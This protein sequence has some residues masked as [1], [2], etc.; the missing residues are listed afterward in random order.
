MLFKQTMNQAVLSKL[1]T[2]AVDLVLLEPSEMMD[3]PLQ[4]VH[5]AAASRR[6]RWT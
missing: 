6:S 2:W 3:T 4:D 5:V 1:P